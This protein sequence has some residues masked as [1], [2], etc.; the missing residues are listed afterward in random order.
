MTASIVEE[1][2][3]SK[4]HFQEY[5]AADSRWNQIKDYRLD[6]GMYWIGKRLGDVIHEKKLREFARGYLSHQTNLD[7][8][9]C[10]DLEYALELWKSFAQNRVRGDVAASQE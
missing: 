3:Q 8:E 4:L 9:E 7:E 6:V 1:P 10:A 2:D 5:V